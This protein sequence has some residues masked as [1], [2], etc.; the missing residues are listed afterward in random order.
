MNGG[1]IFVFPTLTPPAQMAA[2]PA[3]DARSVQGAGRR[4]RALHSLTLASPFRTSVVTRAIDGATVLFNVDTGRS[5]MLDDVGTRAWTVLTAASSVQ[6]AYDTLLAEYRVE[7]ED[8]RRDLEALVNDSAPADYW[9]SGVADP[10]VGGGRRLTAR[11]VAIRRRPGPIGGCS[12]KPV[13]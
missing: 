1:P 9:R 13:A 10:R 4:L 5:F 8:L 6:E 11:L 2:A 3:G 12:S 7:P